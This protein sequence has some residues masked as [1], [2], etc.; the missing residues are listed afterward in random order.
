MHLVGFIIRFIA[1]CRQHSPQFAIEL[2]DILA[3]FLASTVGAT[4]IPARPP[5]GF[6]D[7]LP[8]GLGPPFLQ[9]AE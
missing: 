1:I 2:M 8:Y 4:N 3:R 6:L 5:M 9:T 7:G